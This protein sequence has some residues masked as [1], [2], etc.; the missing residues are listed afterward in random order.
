MTRLTL[1]FALV[2]ILAACSIPA[3]EMRGDVASASNYP[4][5]TVV[6]LPL[7]PTSDRDEGRTKPPAPL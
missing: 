1:S 4:S 5:D 3:E 2:L 6:D 7:V